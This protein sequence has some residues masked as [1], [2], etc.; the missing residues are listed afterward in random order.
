MDAEQSIHELW[1]GMSQF[2]ASRSDAALDYVLAS[3]CRLIDAQY[4]FWMGG[5]R[6]SN[7]FV[8]DP[9]N[10][11]RLAAVHH[12]HDSPESRA[13][14]KQH[15]RRLRKGEVDACF[16]AH[17]RMAGEYRVNINSQVLPQSWFESEFYQTMHAA[18]GKQD[19]IL[20]AVPLGEDVESW[21]GFHRINHARPHF[22]DKEK[23]LL[24]T[25]VRSMKWFHQ[26]VALSHGILL[27][28]KPLTQLERQVLNELL[29]GKSAKDIATTLTL[30]TATV[31]TYTKRLCHKFNVRGRSQ[32]TALWLSS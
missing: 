15:L 7:A 21:F 20:V 26:Q 9:I 30:T 18:Q 27:A 4:A 11:W 8:N 2:G 3:L 19:G 29:T 14:Y 24:F 5:V 32:L 16:V 12:L 25:A 28:E 17:L 6:M 1:D 10:G 13:T 31:S 22:G 23:Q